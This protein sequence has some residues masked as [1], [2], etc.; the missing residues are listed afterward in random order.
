MHV[1][2]YDFGVQIDL[3]KFLFTAFLVR[4]QPEINVLISQNSFKKYIILLITF[5]I[6]QPEL[7]VCMLLYGQL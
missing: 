2:T 5:V 6:H 4:N 1:R 3:I 7:A